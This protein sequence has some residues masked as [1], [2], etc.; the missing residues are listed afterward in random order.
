MVEAGPGA[1]ETQSAADRV[2][3]RARVM[4]R[5]AL[6]LAGVWLATWA[7]LLLPDVLL[8]WSGYSV[9]AVSSF[10]AILFAAV[11]ALLI[12]TAKSRRC[13]LYTS[14]SPRDRS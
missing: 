9:E 3:A 8:Y 7:L 12:T 13:L 10:K 4:L 11:V 14:P 1:E 5:A 2:W 6:P